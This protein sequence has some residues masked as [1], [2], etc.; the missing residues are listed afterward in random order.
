MTLR[1]SRWGCGR[2]F[3]DQES[4]NRHRRDAHNPHRKVFAKERTRDR[5]PVL[6][7]YPACGSSFENEWSATQHRRDKHGEAPEEAE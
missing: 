3:S 6:C 4:L 1:C 2:S 5:G 7:G